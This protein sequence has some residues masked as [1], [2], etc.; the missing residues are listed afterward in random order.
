MSAFPP[1]QSGFTTA[2]GFSNLAP[3]SADLSPYSLSPVVNE[4]PV[5]S[6]LTALPE[7]APAGD[8]APS[9]PSRIP[10]GLPGVLVVLAAVTLG[11]A[12]VGQLV[13]LRNRRQAA[14]S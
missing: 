3:L 12:G 9:F 6:P 4:P 7:A 1:L 14:D 2:S 11:G 13:A 10:G 8:A 5:T